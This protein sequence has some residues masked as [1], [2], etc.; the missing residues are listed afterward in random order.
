MTRED[1][2]HGEIYI[3]RPNYKKRGMPIEEYVVFEGLRREGAKDKRDMRC[4][5]R[6]RKGG[7]AKFVISEFLYERPK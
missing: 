4:K 3:Y 5:V 7:K 6:P 2:E 1:L